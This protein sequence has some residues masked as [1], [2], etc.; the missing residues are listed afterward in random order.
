MRQAHLN[1]YGI[2]C[3]LIRRLGPRL[4]QK[5]DFKV[6]KLG[7]ESFSASNSAIV[8]SPPNFTTMIDRPSSVQSCPLW[9]SKK[10][11]EECYFFTSENMIEILVIDLLQRNSQIRKQMRQFREPIQSI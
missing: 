1:E 4:F 11:Y 6:L 7:N 5:P 2:I 9:R 10:I 8:E 3:W